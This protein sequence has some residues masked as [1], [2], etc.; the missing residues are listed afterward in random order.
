[1]L[2][3]KAGSPAPDLH[4]LHFPVGG[5][6]FRPTL[7]EFLFFLD[8]EKLFTDWHDDQW[9]QYLNETL[10]DFERIQARTTVRNYHDDA[11][12]VLSGLGYEVTPPQ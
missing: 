12:N 11:A 9:R 10:S 4:D 1:M 6:R 2:Y 5:R 3:G 8:K 7:E